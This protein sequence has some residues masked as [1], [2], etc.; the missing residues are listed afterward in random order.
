MK[1]SL[2]AVVAAAATLG[3]TGCTPYTGI[4]SLP[5]PGTEGTGSDS[6]EVKLQ[7][8]NADD[9]VANTP[10]FVNDINVGTTTLV[11][12][13]GW[14]PTL[15]LSLK[16]SVKLPANA[17]GALA[18]TSLLGSKHI[19]LAPR[20]DGPGAGSAQLWPHRHGTDAMFLALL[21]RTDPE[22]TTS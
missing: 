12:L 4:N 8:H 22:R 9:L 15:T 14:Q 17:V 20:G 13:E 6:Y 7:L 21:Q 3:L 5:L 1:R 10:V 2:L 18:Q 11:A 16:N 19:D